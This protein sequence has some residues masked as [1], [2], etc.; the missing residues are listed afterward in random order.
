[1]A[2]RRRNEMARL[3]LFGSISIN[4]RNGQRNGEMK[5]AKIRNNGEK[6]LAAWLI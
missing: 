1:M 6:W 3:K 4:H 5:T 2:L